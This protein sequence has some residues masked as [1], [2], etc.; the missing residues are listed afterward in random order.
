MPVVR[1]D[2]RIAPADNRAPADFNS[3][4]EVDFVTRSN[5]AAVPQ[6]ESRINWIHGVGLG[7]RIYF[8]HPHQLRV[9]SQS[10][11]CAAPD[12]VQVAY[13]HVITQLQICDPD[14]YV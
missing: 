2:R 14:N 3:I 11:L 10:N 5:N 8:V 9:A 7:N 4:R 1:P 12:N 6:G 13:L